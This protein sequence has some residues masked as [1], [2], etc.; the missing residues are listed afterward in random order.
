L[1][2]QET[3]LAAILVRTRVQPEHRRKQE[4]PARVAP[5]VAPGAALVGEEPQA[6]ALPGPLV[7]AAQPGRLA[8]AAVQ[9]APAAAALAAAARAEAAEA[10]PALAA[11]H[12]SQAVKE[13]RQPVHS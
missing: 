11:L 8:L 12:L 4:P 10:V 13:Q 7:M 1:E 6:R 3:E 5:A 2:R 9:R